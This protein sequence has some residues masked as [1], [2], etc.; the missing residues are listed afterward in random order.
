M[1]PFRLCLLAFAL[2]LVTASSALSQPEE[3]DRRLTDVSGGYSF[4][5]PTGFNTQQ[6]DEGTVLVNA[7]QTIL[8]IAKSHAFQTFEMFMAQASL[9]ED[10]VTLVGNAQ[11][12]A[13]KGKHF[14][15]SKRT[16]QGVAIL[17][18]FVLFSPSGGGMLVLAISETANHQESFQRGLQVANSVAFIETQ[19]SGAENEWQAYFQGKRLSYYYNASG[20]TE[21]KHID[22]CRSGR[23]F[24]RS[25][26]ISNSINGL[27]SAPSSSQGTW[28][29]SA[30]GGLKLILQISDGTTREY[31]VTQGQSADLIVLNGK[32]YRVGVS[33]KCP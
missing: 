5:V 16:P 21:S 28:K 2:V 11:E 15:G 20:Y 17:D 26:M 1:K 4:A 19:T 25:E 27:E 31:M 30:R 33:D 32:R 13:G 3:R 18:T 12:I 24:S 8:I 7:D 10:G 9:E 6:N 23:F 22:L 14:R 29:T